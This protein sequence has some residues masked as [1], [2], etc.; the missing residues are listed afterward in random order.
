MNNSCLN[1]RGFVSSVATLAV[2]LCAS[3]NTLGADDVPAGMVLLNDNG[4]WSWF[5]D[6]RAIVDAANGKILVSS[7]G[8]SSG[9]GGTARN[10]DIDLAT[11]DLN[12]M[13][14]SQFQLHNALQADDH[15]SAA[16]IVRPDGHY[17]A[18]YGMHVAG[19]ENGQQSFYRIS[20]NPGDPSSWGSIQSFDNNAS[21]TYSNLHYLPNDNGGAGRMYNFTR[22]NNF[23][24]NILISGDQG[25]SWSYGGKLLTEGGG[26]DRP[27]VR[28]WSD[29]DRIHFI[30]TERHPRDF[31]NSIYYGYVQDGQLF[32]SNGS[33]ADANLFDGS[34]VAPSTLT[35]VFP[36]GTVVDGAAMRRAWTVDVA[37][38]ADHNPVAVFQA[39]A[40]GSDQDHRFFYA[41]WSG[42]SWQV[43]PLAYAGSYLYAAEN[44]YTGLVSIDPNDPNTVYLSSEVH[45]AT[46]AQLI[47]A[48]GLRHYELFKGTTSDGGA[49]WNWAP[50]TFNST[51][52][53]IRPIVPKWDTDNT[54]LLWLRGV[55]STYTNYDT[56]V[57]GLVNPDIADPVLALAVDFGATGQIVQNGFEAF[58]RDVDPDGMSQSESYASAFGA[59]GQPITVSLGG[60]V[61]FADRGDDVAGPIGDVADDFVFLDDTVKVTF[62]NLARGNYQLVLYA[63]DRDVNQLSYDI[64]Q[65]G[66]DLGTLNPVSGTS[67]NIGIASARIAFGASGDGEIAFDLAGIGDGADVVLN[68]LELY[69]VGPYTP[70]VDLNADGD[71]NLTDYMLFLTG[72]HA[73]LSGLTSQEAYKKGDLNG[74]LQNNFV[75]FTLFQQAYD[76]W[77][78]DGALA[79][80]IGAP[81]PNTAS[82]FVIGALAAHATRFRKRAP[83]SSMRPVMQCEIVSRQS[84]FPE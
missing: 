28:Y 32:R 51:V 10:G 80:A 58:T 31:D 19:G 36:T 33:V 55:Y 52:H 60:D 43:N 27:Y 63:H 49:N 59:G 16:L 6:E 68:G 76:Q 37:T 5:Q 66:V 13:A 25:T 1:W 73:D 48:D 64:L 26:G 54:A 70:A 81:E 24:P 2:F 53:N 56:D 23:D 30:A 42:S 57:V 67:P 29:G 61:Q 4:A 82:F 46:Q 72:L 7:V 40:N 84:S 75:D 15:N 71:L 8:N 22:T 17:L 47:G 38:D 12:S 83:T 9:T 79:N 41:R 44:D 11:L 39:R 62:G 45:P 35:S 20:T 69:S 77:N 3:T 50:I 14:V 78:G 34:G 65:D 21:M 18:M 74:D